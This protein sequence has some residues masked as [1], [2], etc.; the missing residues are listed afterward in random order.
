MRRET[1]GK[2][3]VVSTEGALGNEK[4][5]DAAPYFLDHARALSCNLAVST[6]LLLHVLAI[7]CR[8][9]IAGIHMAV[10]L[11]HSPQRHSS[12]LWLL[13]EFDR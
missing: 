7:Q 8:H 1:L 5:G 3:V 10:D 6:A 2:E 4:S 13:R 9:L 12:C 11:L